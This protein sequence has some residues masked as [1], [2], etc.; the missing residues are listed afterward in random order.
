MFNVQSMILV[1]ISKWWNTVGREIIVKKDKKYICI[2]K[3]ET[4]IDEI[5]LKSHFV[6]PGLKVVWF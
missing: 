6:A 1:H 2:I 5:F 3:I 4:E